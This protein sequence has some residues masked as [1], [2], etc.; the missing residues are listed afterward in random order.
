M[1]KIILIS[2][3]MIGCSAPS[4]YPTREIAYAEAA[5]AAAKEVHAER[6]ASDKYQFALEALGNAKAYEK[7]GKMR[8]AKSAAKD[9][10]ALAEEAE[11][12]AVMKL[13]RVP[14]SEAPKSEAPKKELESS[15]EVV[16]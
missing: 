7:K 5:I 2:L 6:L 14:K 8:A 16:Q 3:V 4:Y 9:A 1:N 12:I 13:V 15:P 11:E 10:R